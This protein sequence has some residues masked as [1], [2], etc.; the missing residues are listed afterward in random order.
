MNRDEKSVK[1][2][3]NLYFSQRTFYL[4]KK[5]PL[6]TII[7]YKNTCLLVQYY[8]CGQT[9]NLIPTVRQISRRVQKYIT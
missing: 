3:I 5:K 9:K 1:R 8:I 6:H 4:K 2:Y 7:V